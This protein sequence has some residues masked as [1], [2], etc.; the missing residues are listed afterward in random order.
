MV[1]LGANGNK[2]VYG[3]KHYNVDVE[4]DKAKIPLNTSNPG[5]TVFVIK[6]SKYYMLDSSYKWV[7]IYPYGSGGGNTPGP[8]PEE[9]DGGTVDSNQK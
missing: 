9:F 5:T 8:C 2:I 1:N 7:E 4:E 6:T 3:V